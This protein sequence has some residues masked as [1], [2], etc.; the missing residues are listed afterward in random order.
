MPARRHGDEADGEGRERLK[1]TRNF[2]FPENR[3]GH[4]HTCNDVARD[5]GHAKPRCEP[6][7][8]AARYEHDAEDQ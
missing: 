2:N 8:R 1:H 6:S 5:P 4:E 7:A 3:D